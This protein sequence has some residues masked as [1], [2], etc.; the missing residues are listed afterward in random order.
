MTDMHYSAVVC[1]DCSATATLSWE[2]RPVG[3]PIVNG[4]AWESW[5]RAEISRALVVERETIVRGI[6][7]QIM[8]QIYSDL[9]TDLKTLQ[10]TL[11]KVCTSCAP[12][13]NPTVR[14]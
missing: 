3:R 6:I 11:E 7:E 8:D 1:P 10:A 4:A 5:V 13:S 2:P 12:R 14:P 9:D